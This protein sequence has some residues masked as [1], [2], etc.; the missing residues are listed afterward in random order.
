MGNCNSGE[1]GQPTK[2]SARRSQYHAVP[3]SA[4]HPDSVNDSS[5]NGSMM[6]QPPPPPSSSTSVTPSSRL[7]AQHER[8]IIELLPFRDAAKFQEWLSSIYVQGSWAEFCRDFLSLQP[9]ASEPDK[10]RTA[11]MARDAIVTRAPK[12]LLYHPDK[13]DWTEQ[14]HHVRFIVSVVSDNMLQSRLW[15]EGE[16]KKRSHDIAKAVYEVL[17]YLRALHAEKEI[18]PPGY[19]F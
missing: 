14:D 9:Q 16:W 10:Q 13:R 5:D 3:Q 4:I 11:E 1:E 17:I 12:Y 7:V 19:E 2:G 8:L 6:G 18:N 15:P